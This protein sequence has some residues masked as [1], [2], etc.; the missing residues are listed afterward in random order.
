GFAPLVGVF[1]PGTITGVK[2]EDQNANGVQD[3][4]EAGLGGFTIYIDRNNNGVLDVGEPRTVTAADGSY[5]FDASNVINGTLPDGTVLANGVGPDVILGSAT[6]TATV[7]GAT[8]KVT[9]P[10]GLREVQQV[11]FLG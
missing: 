10:H 4:G 11:G 3:A 7:N 9:G 2:F 6:T 1:R 5:T 8:L